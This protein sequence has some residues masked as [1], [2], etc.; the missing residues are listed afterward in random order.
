M[1]LK[2]FWLIFSIENENFEKI[3]IF[4]F[5]FLTVENI[6]QSIKLSNNVEYQV[7]C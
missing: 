5:K 6:S 2:I 3:D 7:E 1:N 4:L